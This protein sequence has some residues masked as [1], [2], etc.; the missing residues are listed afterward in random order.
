MILFKS[1]LWSTRSERQRNWD[2]RYIISRNFNFQFLSLHNFFSKKSFPKSFKNCQNIKIK[3]LGSHT[4]QELRFPCKD[5]AVSSQLLQ[6][7]ESLRPDRS[8]THLVPLLELGDL[9]N[10]QQE[11]RLECFGQ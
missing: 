9:S 11:S 7:M 2:S 1:F 5:H 6:C 4:A 8:K 10:Q 3:Q